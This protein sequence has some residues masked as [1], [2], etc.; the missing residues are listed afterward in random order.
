MHE[1]IFRALQDGATIITGSRRL[2]RVLA[3]EF[4]WME[5]KRGRTVWNRPD[6]LPLD[7]FL[8]RTWAE[9]LG[10]WADG[11]APV[12]LGAAQEQ[13]LWEQIIRESPAGASLLQIP[14]TARQCVETWR[15]I[16][17]YRLPVDGSFEASEDWAAFASWSREFQR[18]CRLN[19]WLERAR[20]SDFLLEKLAVDEL[21]CP[22]AL[23]TAGF[24]E[25]TPQQAQL[26]EVLGA[27]RAI[28]T[29][30][31]SPV[32]VRRKLR[33]SSEEIR[34]AAAWARR[35][36]EA[37]PTTKIGIIVAPDLTRPRAKVERLFG[38]ALDPG[39]AS[40]EH[41]R[42]FHLSVGPSLAEYPI[43]RAALL[44][45]EF[46]SGNLP[47]PR[48]GMLLRSPFLGGSDK[49]WGKRAQLDAKL[50]K[51]GQW[52]ASLTSLREEAAS[53][54]GAATRAAACRKAD[55]PASGRATAKRVEP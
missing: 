21:S 35:L 22:S 45:V 39:G 20:L 34:S 41:G 49:E 6:A 2:A 1:E 15:L 14:E 44:M 37:D 25:T 27:R 29:Q 8:D 10:R 43:V 46:A 42:A 32:V 53:L 48:A 33:D 31:C 9:W 16:V 55:P 5:A 24:D 3:R 26:F 18:R 52:D 36:L 7:A 19:R 4:H 38:E 11:S 28:E 12:L 40:S 47:L 54:S 50:R 13:M 17:E 23:F 30:A 51:I